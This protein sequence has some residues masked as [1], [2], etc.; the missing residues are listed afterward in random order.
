MDTAKSS[1]RYIMILLV[2][3]PNLERS[4]NQHLNA[5]EQAKKKLNPT[6]H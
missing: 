2:M 5:C 3:Q 1:F 4:H 6:S